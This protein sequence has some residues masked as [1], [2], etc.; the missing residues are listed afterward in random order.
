MSK[1]TYLDVV[2]NAFGEA[3]AWKFACLALGAVCAGLTFGL[4]Y[5]ARNSPVVLVPFNFA[6]MDGKQTVSPNGNFADAS[7]DYLAQIALGDLALVLNWTPDDVLVQYQRFLNRMTPDL[8]AEQN[9]SMLAEANDYRTT[10]T[11]QS[12]YPTGARAT[13]KNEVIVDGTLVRWTGEKE[14]LRMKATYTI[15]YTPFKG[16][17][18]VSGL[19][20]QK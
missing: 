15:S 16:F 13:S 10:G 12:F 7:P 14:S 18:H 2:A 6:T 11:T 3:K 4:V 9:V 19:R 8:Y 20:I 17:L 5:Q 1:T